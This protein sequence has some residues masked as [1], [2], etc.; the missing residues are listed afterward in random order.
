MNKGTGYE[1]E[2]YWSEVGERIDDREEGNVIAGDD[3]PFYRYKRD[4]VIELLKGMNVTG[5]RVL[6]I[7]PGPGGNLALLYE[8]KPENVEGADISQ[9]MIDLATKNLNNP[10]IKITKTNG[11]DLPFED[12]QFDIVFSCTVLQ[13]NTDEASMRRLLSEMCRVSSNQVILLEQTHPSLKGD[14]LCYWRPVAH[15]DDI[16]SAAGY[17]LSKVEY[18]NIY[19]SYLVAGFARKVLNP[20]NR[21]EGEPLTKFSLGV[22][23]VFMPITKALDKVFTP[24]TDLAKMVFSRK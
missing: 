23:R 4:R 6:E 13:H 3:E 18:S 5:K 21:Q 15:Y 2:N 8:L 16:C 19:M 12:G 11:K 17:E 14:E 7:G 22:Q 20:S 24:K 1:P 9:T 10:E